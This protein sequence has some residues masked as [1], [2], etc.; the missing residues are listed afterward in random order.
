MLVLVLAYYELVVALSD[1]WLFNYL[2]LLLF[3][4]LLLL[5]SSHGLNL[6]L[7]NCLSCQTL[8][9]QPEMVV[10]PVVA[11]LPHCFL[12]QPITNLCVI[13]SMNL[14]LLQEDLSLLI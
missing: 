2:I 5:Q 11:D 14:H 6:F 10:E 8:K 12:R 4:F 13:A 3:F 9:S 7:L 1:I